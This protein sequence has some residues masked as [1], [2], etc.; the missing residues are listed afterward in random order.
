MSSAIK[1]RPVYGDK[2]CLDPSG[3]I[4]VVA[5][6]GDAAVALLVSAL[7]DARETIAVPVRVLLTGADMPPGIPVLAYDD[8]GELLRGL[9][10]LLDIARM[11][12]RLYAVGPEAFL[13][14]VDG[15]A[16]SYGFGKGEVAKLPAGTQ[17][18]KVYCSHCK[19]VSDGVIANLHRCPGC[20]VTLQV[21]D[22]FSRR[23]G[24]FMGVKAD[25]EE[26]G[27]LPETVELYR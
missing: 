11:G 24:A 18:R 7:E 10:D 25:A 9:H 20:G 16:A 8:E 4:H 3:R 12:L 5:V 2:L 21:R 6:S 26:P 22:H 17:A 15:V 14:A 23:L 1:S 13:W 19:A 27:N